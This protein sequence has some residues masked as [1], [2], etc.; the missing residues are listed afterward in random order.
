MAE[1]GATEKAFW[2]VIPL[3]GEDALGSTLS[4]QALCFQLCNTWQR[5][6][7]PWMSQLC[8]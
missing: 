1:R 4:P 2:G 8:W 3:G 6:S 5:W 7:F